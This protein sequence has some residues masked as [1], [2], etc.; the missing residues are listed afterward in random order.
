MNL[1]TSK[2]LITGGSGFIG[3]N[4]TTKLLERGAEV[5]VLDNLFAGKR[6][7]IPNDAEFHE[8]DL[9]NEEIKTI[10][11]EINPDVIIHLAAIHYIP[12][13]NENPEE[14]FDVNVI[15]TRNLLEAT[16]QVENVQKA[17]FASSAAVY[18]PRSQANTEESPLGPID[19]YG[20]TKLLGEDLMELYN[21]KT[22]VPTASARLFN[23]YGPNETNAHLIPA[24]V[25]QIQEGNRTIELGN[26]SP[27][28]D[29]V[30]VSDVSEAIISL[31]KEFDGDHRAY[32][33][34]TCNEHSVEEVVQKTSVALGEEIKI[35]QDAERVRESDRPHLQ[36]DISRIQNEIGW[37]PSISFTEG[38]RELLDEEVMA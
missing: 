17:V 30:H 4:F 28:R 22:R 19:I 14:A 23:V 3:S 16:R 21:E 27:K 18:P 25:K 37:S 34:G 33:V 6:S 5:H 26:L 1:K 20:K 38:L 7:L 15:G 9:R 13:C 35:E 24:I 2:V 8:G 31:A 11:P 36:A 32:N 10:V 12:Y 29:F